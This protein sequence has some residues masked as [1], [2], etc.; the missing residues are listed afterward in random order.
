MPAGLNILALA[1][2]ALGLLVVV[3]LLIYLVG[4]LNQ[5]E[6]QTRDAVAQMQSQPK[7]VMIGPFGGLSGKKLWDIMVG[8]PLPDVTPEQVEAAREN[9][10]SVL[11]RH[12]VQTFE[13]GMA[14]GKKGITGNPKNPRPVQTLRGKV[15]SWL[16]GNQLQTIYQCAQDVANGKAPDDPAIQ[17]ALEV[18]CMELHDRA[19]VPADKDYVQVLL[20][21]LDGATASPNASITENT[22]NS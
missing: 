9:Y 3:V 4:R 6:Q 5:V 19:G 2:I 20:G 12:I 7:P 14:D 10:P 21:G 17:Q 15:D 8:K 18:A 16:P 22:G 11:H 1:L 13:E